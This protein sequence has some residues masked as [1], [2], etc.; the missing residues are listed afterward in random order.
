MAIEWSPKNIEDLMCYW[1]VTY[2]NAYNN[3][4]RQISV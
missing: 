2:A 3:D 4:F 1:L